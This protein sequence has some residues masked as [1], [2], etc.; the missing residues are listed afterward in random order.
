MSGIRECRDNLLI[1]AK[2]R[3]EGYSKVVGR[4]EMGLRHLEFGLLCLASGEWSGK[5]GRCEQALN[6]Y[7][8]AISLETSSESFPR[9]GDRKNPFTGAPTV[10]YLPPKTQ[11]TVKV[12]DGPVEIGVFSATAPKFSGDVMV[13][14]PSDMVTR[15]V[16]QDNWQRE[17]HTALGTNADVAK[18]ILTEVLVPPGN[19]ASIPE[20][21]H[22]A[23]NPPAEVPLEEIC[24]FHVDPRQGFGIMRIYTGPNDPGPMNEV[25]VVEDGDTVV[26]P[27]GYH[28]I[29]AAPGYAISYTSVLA[30]DVR[31]PGAVS[32]DPRHAWIAEEDG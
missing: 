30:G 9:L 6:V 10:V 26:V 17:S 28:L 23:F 2:A 11:Y 31:I 14:R 18:L 1:K 29:G 5:T 4:G 3:P 22:D 13:V 15:S 12:V 24:H 32:F 7:S 16:G 8:G 19:W 20:H 27:R 21:K 25:Y